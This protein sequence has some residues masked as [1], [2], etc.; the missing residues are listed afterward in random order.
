MEKVKVVFADNLSKFIDELIS[1]WK[2]GNWKRD[3]NRLILEGENCLM[4]VYGYDAVPEKA[5]WILQKYKDI[6]GKVLVMN[7]EDK[8]KESVKEA[9]MFL[10][11]ASVE[12]KGD[13][14][15]QYSVVSNF[16]IY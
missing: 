7:V 10:S 2:E 12:P 8:D 4:G 15:G 11:F 3:A 6:D 13:T 16:A 9:L 14:F 1:A 5:F